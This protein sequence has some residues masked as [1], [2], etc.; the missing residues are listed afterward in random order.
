VKTTKAAMN[1]TMRLGCA[2]QRSSGA[3]FGTRGYPQAEPEALWLR[4]PQRGWSQT[5]APK[6]VNLYEHVHA[7][8]TV[9]VL[10]IDVDLLVHVVVVGFLA[11]K[12]K[13]AEAQSR[14]CQTVAA[15][16][17]ELADLPTD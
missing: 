4:A 13:G 12:K 8:I 2:R 10:D 3:D 1:Y 11:S 7:T 6:A 16:P 14:K 17:A 5:N 9:F 15:S